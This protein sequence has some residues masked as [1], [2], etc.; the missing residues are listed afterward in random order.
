MEKTTSRQ[1]WSVLLAE[2]AASGQSKKDFCAQR[3]LNTATFYYWQRQLQSVT[4]DSTQQ[5]KPSTGGF[6]QLEPQV[7]HELTLCLGQ[8]Q[9]QVRSSSLETL[10][11]LVQH[12]SHA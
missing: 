5:S 7:S 3:N 1:R 11:G 4:K 8:G 6:T 12:L 10:A 2:Q 9:V